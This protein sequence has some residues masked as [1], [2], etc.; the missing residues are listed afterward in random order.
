MGRSD[1]WIIEDVSIASESEDRFDHTSVAREIGDIARKSTHSL[2]IGLLGRYGTGKSSV[3]RLLH[4]ELNGRKWAVLQVSAERHTGVARGRG[5][6]Y[7][8]IDEAHRQGDDVLSAEEHKALRASLEG[9][10]QRTTTLNVTGDGKSKASWE[11]YAHAAGNGLAWIVGLMLAVWVIGAVITV[12]VHLLHAWPH[13]KSWTWFTASGATAPTAFLLSGAVAATV[14]VAAK[15]GAQHVLRAYDITLTTP[16]ADTADELEQAFLRLVCQVKRRVVVAIDDI[17]RLAADDVLDALSTVRSLLLVGAHLERPPV[18]L[19]SCDEEIVREAIIGVSP[20]LAHRPIH[21]LG[22]DAQ[23]EHR[24]AAQAADEYLNKLFT[25]RIALPDHHGLDMR[26]YAGQLLKE[27]PITTM[28]SASNLET[29]LDVLIHDR[30]VD[31]RHVIRLL[32]GFLAHYRLGQ[33]REA[34]ANGSPA[35]IAEGEV[36]DYPVELARLTALQYDFRH[37]Y[38]AVAREHELLHLLDDTILADAPVENADPLLNPYLRTK[39]PAESAAVPLDYAAHPGLAYLRTV[40][41]TVRPHRAPAIGPLLTLGSE[42]DSRQL[43]GETARA[44]RAELQGRDTHGFATRLV[45]PDGRGRVLQ[46]AELVLANARHGLALDNAL[47]TAASALGQTQNALS[48]GEA[49]RLA[50]TI[51]RRRSAMTIPLEAEDLAVLLA[52]S[53]EALHPALIATLQQAPEDAD[54]CRRWA[55]TLLNLSQTP[56]GAHFAAMLDEYF[57]NAASDAESNNEDLD[58]WLDAWERNPDQAL[59]TWPTS[60]YAFALSSAARHQ[61]R[62]GFSEIVLTG[63]SRHRWGRP[64]VLGLLDCLGDESQMRQVT[65]ELLGHVEIPTDEWGRDEG[66]DQDLPPSSTVAVRLAE[67]V[68]S[69]LREEQDDAEAGKAAALLRAWLPHWLATSNRTAI[70]LTIDALVETAD[71]S[72]ALAE[73]SA[74]LVPLLPEN[75]VARYAAALAA[76]LTPQR[77][78]NPGIDAALRTTLIN[79]LHATKDS[80]AAATAQ[81]TAQVIE[82]LTAG[83]EAEAPAGD[84]AHKSLPYLLT[85]QQGSAHAPA[86]AMRVINA[87]PNQATAHALL[88][89]SLLHQLFAIPAAREQHLPQALGRVQQWINAAQ[90]GP[91]MVF[92]AHYSDQPAV[93]DQWLAWIGQHWAALAPAERNLVLRAAGRTELLPPHAAAQYLTPLLL[94]H[95]LD[96]SA[97]APWHSAPRLWDALN[98]DQRAQLLAAERGRCRELAVQAAESPVPVLLGTLQRAGEDL[99]SVLQL[100]RDAPGASAALNHFIDELL[101]APVW[102]PD[103]ADKAIAGIADP[104]AVW[105]TALSAAA[106]GRDSLHRAAHVIRALAEQHPD[107]VPE[108]FVQDFAPLVHDC[109]DVDT[110]AVLGRAVQPM[111]EQARAV[112]RTL[113]GEHNTTK[114][115]KDR[116]SAFRKAA[117]IRR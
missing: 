26:E 8:L 108:T 34:A 87:I 100:L 31:P 21:T 25:V 54:R 59:A 9:G 80:N 85:T 90:A 29:I 58:Y 44:I 53:S 19:L 92:A 117:G 95:L 13:V 1:K 109:T 35:R 47:T 61:A 116:T 23:G 79:F 112:S 115:Q 40:A 41:P 84:F 39:S 17:D 72:L 98:E 20:G 55:T 113:T 65:L 4:Q 5:L 3:V 28:V 16:R 11:K 71:T 77:D 57:L 7:G 51:V 93:T 49:R 104:T 36:T 62:P 110:A 32:N 52:L 42:P 46:A 38:E 66:E 97:D 78:A 88:L 12:L 24:A 60:A 99:E 82:S 64:V 22:D 43:G 76:R 67:R 105:S 103:S 18:F 69:T 15:E 96:S 70:D 27:H 94:D 114:E 63:A 106:E 10:Q 89:T 48:G 6:L 68:S 83:L 33:R 37:L 91:A 81:A 86:L 75:D 111:R 101:Q 50:D 14:I 56:H 107:S 30:V 45:E 74:D 102:Q 73:T 2:A